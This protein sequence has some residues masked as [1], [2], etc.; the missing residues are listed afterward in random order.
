MGGVSGE[1]GKRGWEALVCVAAQVGWSVDGHIL[2]GH[3]AQKET[4]KPRSGNRLMYRYQ[5]RI[6]AGRKD[7]SLPT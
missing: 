1:G 3:G 2:H 4:D 7:W 5:I 6:N